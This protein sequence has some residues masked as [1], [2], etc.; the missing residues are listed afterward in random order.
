MHV[1]VSGI[2]CLVVPLVA[3]S[4]TEYVAALATLLTLSL[5]ML[6]P[7]PGAARVIGVKPAE[8]PLGRPVT[9]NATGAVNP[10]LTVTERLTVLLDPM[11][12]D[13][14]LDDATAWKVGVVVASFQ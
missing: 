12:T 5:T 4:V 6:E 8:N 13:I 9:E 1:I 11:V 2:C 14:A 3:T 10:P 7:E